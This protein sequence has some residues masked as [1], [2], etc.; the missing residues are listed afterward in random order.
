M[1]E[2]EPDESPRTNRYCMDTNATADCIPGSLASPNTT[3]LA[4]GIY[5]YRVRTCTA[6]GRCGPI[7]E[8][9]IKIDTTPPTAASL[10]IVPGTT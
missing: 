2:P 1:D 3:N 9:I 8:F 4:D 10:S 5:Y 6:A 7:S